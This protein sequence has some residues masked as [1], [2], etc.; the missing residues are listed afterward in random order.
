MAK[1]DLEDRLQRARS[2]IA[3]SDQL[4]GQQWHERFLFL[5]IA[6]NALYGRRQYEGDRTDVREDLDRFVSQLKQMNDANARS[7]KGLI[8]VAVRRCGNHLDALLLDYFLQDDLFR[9][10][11][12]EKLVRRCRRELLE[13]KMK[14]LTGDPLAAVAHALRRLTVLRN[15][16]MHGCVTYG[17][18]SKGPPSIVKGTRVAAVL[19][20]AFI[21]LVAAYGSQI[22]WQ[23]IPY[24]RVG[25]E[26]P[27]ERLD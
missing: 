6:L 10:V 16:V 15:R 3:A 2:W 26:D 13:A 19:V 11:Q 18:T 27:Q 7:G 12:R 1:R 23:P 24:P 22:R 20:P 8:L 5:Y 21:E 4:S 17:E 25:F 9:D 14:L